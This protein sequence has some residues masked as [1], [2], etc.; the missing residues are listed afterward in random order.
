MIVQTDDNNSY[1]VG[2]RGSYQLK[3]ILTVLTSIRELKNNGFHI[4]EQNIKEG[5]NDVVEE[6]V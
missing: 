3:N 1:S 6:T 5:L 2:L 4:T